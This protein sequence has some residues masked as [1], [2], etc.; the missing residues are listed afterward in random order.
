MGSTRRTGWFPAAS[1]MA[2]LIALLLS[3]SRAPWLA[4]MLAFA[5]VQRMGSS[6]VMLGGLT[7]AFGVTMTLAFAPQVWQAS[8]SRFE[9]LGEWNFSAERSARSRL[10]IALNSPVFDVD[11]YW[12]IGHGHSSYRFVAEE[13]LSR[14]TQGVSRSLYNFFLT[15]WYDAG[16]AGLTLWI[17]FFVQLRRQ[18]ASIYK[19]SPAP[20]VRTLAWGLIGAWWGLALASM[21][22]EVPYHWRVM[23]AFY[24]AAGVCLAA[25]QAAREAFQTHRVVAWRLTS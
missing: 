25:D 12:L 13:H 7:L 1:F 22:G 2:S 5:K 21:F 10:E 20:E 6:R 18:L 24:L 15:A 14:I 9:A 11:Q 19:R 3:A 16:P 23:G 4:G 8:F 17:L